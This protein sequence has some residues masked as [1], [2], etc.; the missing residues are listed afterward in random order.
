MNKKAKLFLFLIIV[1]FFIFIFGQLLR[2]KISLL[3]IE[4]TLQAIDIIPLI[5]LILY[6]FGFMKN[7]NSFRL[8]S[9]FFASSF[10]SLLL[11]LTL[12]TKTEIIIG[13]LYLLRLISYSTF[14]LMV[15]NYINK[16]TAKK[17]YLYNILL[18]VTFIVGFF[19]WIQFVWFPDLRDLRYV[20]WDDHL[21]RMV[22][23]FLD[24]TFTAIILVFGYV[25]SL[26]KLLYKKENRLFF[27]VLLLYFLISVLFTYT[28]AAYLALLLITISSVIIYKKVKIN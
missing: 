11:S 21:Y 5:S 20:G 28:R 13:S 6:L 8:I 16:S 1:Y 9:V 27:I 24:P 14:F 23:T 10:F 22:G 2:L 26:N 18:F 17:K 4:I 19:A 7:N 12:F 25:L 15:S 3:N